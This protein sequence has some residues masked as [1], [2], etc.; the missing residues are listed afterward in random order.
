MS[1]KGDRNYNTS[2]I[3]SQPN[4]AALCCTGLCHEGNNEA[5]KS[6]DHGTMLSQQ[7]K[8]LQIE[9]KN[10]GVWNGSFGVWPTTPYR[11]QIW[12]WRR[13]HSVK[14]SYLTH[15]M[16]GQGHSLA[17]TSRY[18]QGISHLHEYVLP[19]AS[20]SYRKT[21]F[22]SGLCYHRSRG[23]EVPTKAGFSRPIIWRAKFPRTPRRRL[24]KSNNVKSTVHLWA[25]QS[26]VHEET[27]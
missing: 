12:V 21:S 10:K 4:T 25:F 24:G 16:G 5:N 2:I 26:S 22:W 19:T 7:T 6:T 23:T 13:G 14:D 1:S 3:L 17:D 11:A 9:W 27:D 18:L 8:T 15:S 20:R